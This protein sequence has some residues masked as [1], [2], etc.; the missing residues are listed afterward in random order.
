[1]KKFF[2][3]FR[4]FISK[5]NI[6]DL[7]VGVIIGGAFGKI[8]T[9]LVND[10]IMPFIVLIS[11]KSS[12]SE[13]TWTLRQA[14]YENEVLIQKALTINWGNFLQTIIDFV[15]IGFTVFL[16]IKLI[17]A[18][19]D[20]GGKLSK[21][22]ATAMEKAIKKSKK[23]KNAVTAEETNVQAA[24]ENA[25]QPDNAEVL[26][27]STTQ[28]SQEVQPASLGDLKTIEALLTDIKNALQK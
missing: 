20:M 2:S 16:F 5:G 11:G 22:A 18:A 1:M 9:S 13:L 15:I 27:D 24:T 28:T 14:V 23:D 3:D 25:A 6:L 21:E 4:D 26:K 7:A 17:M 10:I 12:L 19:K 8:V